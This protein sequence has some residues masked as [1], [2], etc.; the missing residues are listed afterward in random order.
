MGTNK[1]TPIAYMGVGKN[2]MWEMTTSHEGANGYH[3]G[4]DISALSQFSA[5]SEVLF[6]PLTML[7]VN[8][9]KRADSPTLAREP[10]LTRSSSNSFSQAVTLASR[11]ASS[12]S[13]G[14]KGLWK[15]LSTKLAD[16]SDD[17]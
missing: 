2:I 5:E 7:R 9:K 16:N 17:A 13:G 12:T 11:T 6:P 8:K 4:A 14:G 10:S 1:D 15:F 3:N